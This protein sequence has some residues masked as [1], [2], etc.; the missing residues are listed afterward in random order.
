VCWPG[1]PGR[2]GQPLRH[3]DHKFEWTRTEFRAWATA[4]AQQHG[5]AVEFVDIGRALQEPE[6]L[7]AIQ[8][9]QQAQQ[10]QQEG[11]AA[12]G[13]RGP[14]AA[15]AAGDAAEVVLSALPSVTPA[16]P[17][18]ATAAAEA[19]T[20][21][22]MGSA[23]AGSSVG[24]MAAAAAVYGGVLGAAKQQQEHQEALVAG[25]VTTMSPRA[26]GAAA[27]GLEPSEQQQQ[28]ESFVMQDPFQ[29][30]YQQ[31]SLGPGGNLG[32]ATQAAVFR[33][34][35]PATTAAA[36]AGGCGAGEASSGGSISQHGLSCVWGPVTAVV[37]VGCFTDAAQGGGQASASSDVLANVEVEHF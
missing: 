28:Q 6:A 14:A 22:V 9:Q 30:P 8:Q 33:L 37:R 34:L 32:G 18:A 26:H 7:A 20:A 27:E 29:D 31:A 3:D 35:D 11:Q 4:L 13:L 1:A 21:A 23:Q 12:F 2:D 17:Q 5:Y 10:G 25:A 16:A 19:V 15:A 24:D 36:A